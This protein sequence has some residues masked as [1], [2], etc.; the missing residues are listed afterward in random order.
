MRKDVPRGQALRGDGGR[1]GRRDEG[2]PL[3][4]FEANEDGSFAIVIKDALQL[5]A[6]ILTTVVAV[7]VTV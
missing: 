5:T 6:S 4:Q 3:L 7:A 1:D 2:T